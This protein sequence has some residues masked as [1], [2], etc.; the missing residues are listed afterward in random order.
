MLQEINKLKEEV[1]ELKKGQEV[2]IDT[3]ESLDK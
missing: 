3:L 1:D 2:K